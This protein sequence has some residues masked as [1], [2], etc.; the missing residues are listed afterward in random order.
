MSSRYGRDWL[1]CLTFLHRVLK[2]RRNKLMDQ[3]LPHHL[4]LG[5]TSDLGSLAIPFVDKSFG[6]DAENGRVRLT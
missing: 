4:L 1:F 3:I 5:E 6:V 2:L